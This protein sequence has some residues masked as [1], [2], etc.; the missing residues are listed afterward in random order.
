MDSI[1]PKPWRNPGADISD[2][3]NYEL[4]EETWEAYRKKY[5]EKRDQ[6]KNNT[7]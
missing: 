7:N 3:F 5:H 2:Y 1:N 6:L 4:N